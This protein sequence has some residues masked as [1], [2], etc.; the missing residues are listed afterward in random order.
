MAR[1]A[2]GRVEPKPQGDAGHDGDRSRW[3]ER[4]GPTA[5]APIF[6]EG[7]FLYVQVSADF[8]RGGLEEIRESPGGTTYRHRWV[9]GDSAALAVRRFAWMAEGLWRRESCLVVGRRET[10][11][12]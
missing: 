3:W 6:T 4:T 10:S 5:G 12:Q 9:A 8:G 1:S 7:I 11:L 2:W